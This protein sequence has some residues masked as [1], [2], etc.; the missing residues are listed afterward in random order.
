MRDNNEFGK[1]GGVKR[2]NS[3]D[4]IKKTKLIAAVSKYN[5]I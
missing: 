1:C 4:G 5:L 3:L 2:H